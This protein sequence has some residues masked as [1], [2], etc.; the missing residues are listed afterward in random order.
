MLCPQVEDCKLTVL[1]FPFVAFLLALLLFFLDAFEFALLVLFFFLA[2]LL[3]FD[4]GIALDEVVSCPGKDGEACYCHFLFT[5]C[6]VL[7]Q[8][9]DVLDAVFNLRLVVF[10]L[11]ECVPSTSPNWHKTRQTVNRKWQ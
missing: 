10:F 1:V 9:G 4:F 7:C 3:P 2:F 5:V 8:F 6:L 11:E